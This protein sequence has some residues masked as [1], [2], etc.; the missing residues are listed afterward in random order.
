[1]CCPVGRPVLSGPIGRGP[2][3]TAGQ[4]WQDCNVF[5]FLDD[6][7]LVKIATLSNCYNSVVFQRRPG[8]QSGRRP[9]RAAAPVVAEALAEV[10]TTLVGIVNEQIT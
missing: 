5:E 8:A 10:D 9:D 7:D 4:R 6:E 2:R 1:M 3:Q